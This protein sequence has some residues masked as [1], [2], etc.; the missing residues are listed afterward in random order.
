MSPESR[1]RPRVPA[2][3]AL[4]VGVLALLLA[5]SVLASASDMRNELGLFFALSLLPLLLG[6]G[7]IG[8]FLARYVHAK[9]A[10]ATCA[11]I[12]LVAFAMLAFRLKHFADQN[13]AWA[14]SRAVYSLCEKAAPIPD[15]PALGGSAPHS[16]RIAELKSD[17]LDQGERFLWHEL[18]V[19]DGYPTD[20]YASELPE[21]VACMQESWTEHERKLYHGMGSYGSKAYEIVQ[22]R[23]GYEI[24]VYEAKTRRLVSHLR[25]DGPIPPPLPSESKGAPQRRG[26]RA[27]APVVLSALQPIIQGRLEPSAH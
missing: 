24:D 27:T 2:Y 22:F 23:Q 10:L 3:I 4:A 20:L 25:V 13:A 8:R 17:P 1:P 7:L 6:L 11:A 12:G 15:A 5:S 26:P 14:R 19:A 21:L 16:I 9:A 18:G